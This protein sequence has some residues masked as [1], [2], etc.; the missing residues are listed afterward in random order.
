MLST[1]ISVETSANFALIKRRASRPKSSKNRRKS[2]C[3]MALHTQVINS[4]ASVNRPKTGCQTHF[5]IANSAHDY[6]NTQNAHAPTQRTQRT[7]ARDNTR[8]DIRTD[9]HWGNTSGIPKHGPVSA[10]S[11]MPGQYPTLQYAY[12]VRACVTKLGHAW[13]P[14][15]GEG[16]EE[17][18][19][20]RE[21]P[22]GRQL[23]RYTNM[24]TIRQFLSNF[25][26]ACVLSERK[27]YVAG[28]I[29]TARMKS[30]PPQG[31]HGP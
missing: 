29:R 12:P 23:I 13:N 27:T 31:P 1:K 10:G 3:G 30:R 28:A 19:G 11:G 7:H 16:T 9:C 4:P 21:P 24:F 20:A 5:P 17:G 15:G 8:R 2:S 14:T 25:R 18:Q 22:K 26:G 6:K